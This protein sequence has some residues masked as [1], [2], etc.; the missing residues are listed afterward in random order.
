MLNDA[1]YAVFSSGLGL[2]IHGRVVGG[3]SLATFYDLEFEDD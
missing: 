1:D 2:F 3:M